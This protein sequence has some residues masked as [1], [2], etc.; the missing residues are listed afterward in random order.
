MNQTPPGQRPKTELYDLATDPAEAKDVAADH[1][2][3]V[4]RLEKIMADQ[5]EP[6]TLFPLPGID[7]TKPMARRNRQPAA[8]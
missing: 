4:A 6:S 3:V 8:E 1:P 7:P 2:D 5:H